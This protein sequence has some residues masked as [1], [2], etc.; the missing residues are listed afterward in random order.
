MFQQFIQLIK[1]KNLTIHIKIV[2]R[3]LIYNLL[4]KKGW[5]ICINV[6]RTIWSFAPLL[7]QKEKRTIWGFAPLF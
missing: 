2:I 3:V 7:Y 4:R 1:N 6:K 5:L